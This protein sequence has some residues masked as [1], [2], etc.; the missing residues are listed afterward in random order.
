M[1]EVTLSLRPL[2]RGEN[3]GAFCRRRA[4][5]VGSHK[6]HKIT[7]KQ[8]L[9]PD[10]SASNRLVDDLKGGGSRDLPIGDQIDR[11]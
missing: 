11:V 6:A 9:K 2:N 1:R 3:W 8:W 4:E 7:Y 10:V 5:E